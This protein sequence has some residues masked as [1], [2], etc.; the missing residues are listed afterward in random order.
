M[1]F[2]LVAAALL[3]ALMASATGEARAQNAGPS[4]A[5]TSGGGLAATFRNGCVV[6]YDAGGRRHSA[7]RRCRNRQIERADNA[8]ARALG[9]SGGQRAESRRGGRSAESGGGGMR[10]TPGKNGRLAV[11]FGS[12]CV[13]RYG[14][15]GRRRNAKGCTAAEVSSADSAAATYRSGR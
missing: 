10:V 4:L 15:D 11:S 9:R 3:T 2:R 14:S 8:V 5:R 6:T 7:D 13:V 12:G 1:S